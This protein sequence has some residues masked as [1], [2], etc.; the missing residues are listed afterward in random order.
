MVL[1]QKIR[2]G[3]PMRTL[4][5]AEVAELLVLPEDLEVQAVFPDPTQL[6]L[7]LACTSPR[8]CCPQCQAPSERI[9]AT[10]GALSPICLVVGVV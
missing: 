10:M 3:S 7:R 5:M 2:R 4:T 6:T 9:I 1:A 8:A